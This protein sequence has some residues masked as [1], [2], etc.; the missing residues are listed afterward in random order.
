MIRP[1]ETLSKLIA[2]TAKTQ[3]VSTFYTGCGA[4]VIGNTVKA[5]VEIPRIRLH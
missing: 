2:N 3:G 5:A 4:F 1:P